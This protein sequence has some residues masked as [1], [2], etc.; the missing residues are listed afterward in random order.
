[1]INIYTAKEA[2]EAAD[3]FYGPLG[4][5]FNAIRVNSKDG[6]YILKVSGIELSV[7]QLEVLTRCGYT[8][9][10]ERADPTTEETETVGVVYS[11]K[12]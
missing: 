2:K 9:D 5:I 11:I 7:K 4:Q 3:A 6:L 8:V 10:A 12:W 1:M